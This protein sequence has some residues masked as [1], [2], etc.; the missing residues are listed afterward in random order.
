VSGIPFAS[1]AQNSEDVVL[2]RALRNVVDGRY[3]DVGANHPTDDSVSRAFYDRGWRGITVEPVPHFANLLRQERP[4]DLVV[5]AAVT[6]GQGEWAILHEIPHTGLSTLDDAIAD[7]HR[8]AGYTVRDVSVRTRTLDDILDDA[9]WSDADDIHF[10]S[11]DTE[12]SEA[13]VLRS[14]DLQRWRPWVLVIESVAPN[15]FVPT[16]QNWEDE[17][18]R[19]GYRCCLFD[20]L[21]RFY[22]AAEHDHEIGADLAAPANIHDNFTTLR[23]RELQGDRD[24]AVRQSIHWRTVALERWGEV[25]ENSTVAA[26]RASI[27]HRRLQKEF[28]D[29]K[30]TLSWR[31]TKPLRSIRERFPREPDGE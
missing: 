30:A 15:S 8:K 11:I 24:A 27:E 18:C 12:G 22:V 3:L 9:G 16:H 20:G 26:S 2:R 28:E 29:L 5:E 21:S 19:A 7:A 14:I 25:M 31:V 23:Q 6:S 1:F 17:V 13:A 4:G 10:L